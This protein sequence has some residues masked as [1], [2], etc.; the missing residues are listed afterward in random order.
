MDQPEIPLGSAA[1]FKGENHLEEQVRSLRTLTNGL[2]VAIL[3]L[4]LGLALYLYRQVTQLNGQ[5]TEA[6]RVIAE[7]QT[8]A[9]P[10]IKW[11]VGS[12][13]NF[14]KTNPDFNPVLA[15]YGL[16]PTNTDR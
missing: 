8:N 9:L 1:P 13:Q 10:R 4:G 5:V 16:L 3:C 7:Y 14:A 15:K 2:L 11:F 6:K 12:L